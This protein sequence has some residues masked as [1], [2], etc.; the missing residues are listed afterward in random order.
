MVYARI[1]RALEPDPPAVW[2]QSQVTPSHSQ[3]WF[4][5]ATTCM[6]Y[7][8]T[9]GKYPTSGPAG[10]WMLRQRWRQHMLPISTVLWLD[11][12]LPEWHKYSKRGVHSRRWL[13]ERYAG[14]M[15]EHKQAYGRYPNTGSAGRWIAKQRW[16]LHQK[17]LHAVDKQWLDCHLPGW[18]QGDEEVSRTRRSSHLKPARAAHV[19]TK[20]ARAKPLRIQ[21]ARD[22]PVGTKAVRMRHVNSKPAR[23][24]KLARIRSASAKPARIR[25]AGAEPVRIRSVRSEPMRIRSVPVRIRSAGPVRIRSARGRPACANGCNDSTSWC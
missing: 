2:R 10:R 6:Q 25:Y 7:M 20:P 11:S 22:K 8:N 16:R 15:I 3:T 1:N 14:A 18:R 23:I 4:D 13:W 5:H 12:V 24:A 9:H 19:S 17:Q 21:S